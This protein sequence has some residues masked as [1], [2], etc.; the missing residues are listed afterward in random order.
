MKDKAFEE[1][2]ALIKTFTQFHQA[3]RACIDPPI[4]S[5]RREIQALEE[6]IAAIS[7]DFNETQK[8][9]HKFSKMH[10][11]ILGDLLQQLLFQTKIKAAI[12]AKKDAADKDKQ[13]AL[14]EAEKDHE[15]YTKSHEAAK[16]E[17]L[18]VLTRAE[19]KELKRLYRQTSLKCHPDRVVEE[20]HDQTEEIFVALNQAYKANDLEKVR[21]INQQLKSGIMLSKSEGVTELKK[22]ESTYKSLMQKLKTWQEKLDQLKEEASFKAVNSIDNWE[23]YF[24]EKKAILLDQLKRLKEFNEEAV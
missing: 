12:D 17:K 16:K 13:E 8:T 5:Y 22:L 14:E 21:E 2:L 4:D 6:E 20:L 7:N 3:L 1:A 9:I 19:Q 23:T 24:Q 11:D 10:T 18:T 15:E